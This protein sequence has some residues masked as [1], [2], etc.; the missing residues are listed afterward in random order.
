M[1]VADDHSGRRLPRRKMH[2]CLEAR[3]AALFGFDDEALGTV[4]H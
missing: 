4:L 2:D 3:L 1:G